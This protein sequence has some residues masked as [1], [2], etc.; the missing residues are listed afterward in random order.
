MKKDYYEVLGVQKESTLQQVKKAYRSKALKYHPDRVEE[1]KKKESEEKFKE[2]SEAYG[3][4]SDPKKRKM[5]DQYGH[6]GIDQ[7]FTSDDIFKGAD[8]GSVF[9]DSGLGDIF[10]QIFGESNFDIFGSSQKG[11]RRAHRGR[12][13][14]YEIEISLEE[15]YSG[16]KKKIK[17]P[18]NEHC[19]ACDG[20]GAKSGNDLKTC[21]TCN[22]RGQV[23]MASGFFRMAQT[24]SNCSGRGQIITDY[25]P[26][27]HGKGA[28][29]ATR[30]IDVNVPAGVNNS[31]R[32]R[33]QNEG[34]IG[35]AGAGDLY[36]YV[37]VLDHD[38][39]E[40]DEQHLYMRLPLSFVKAALGSNVSIPTING[41]VSMKI[42]AGTQSGKVFRLKGRGMPDLRTGITGDLFAR[43]M[44]EVPKKLSKE[45]RKILEEYAKI[46]NEEVSLKGETIKEK[47]KKVFK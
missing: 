8:F 11:S 33:V 22:G 37:H 2:I 1:G 46:S 43:V 41:N 14:Q 19:K 20:S 23:M 21:Q 25:C 30:S 32:L 12:D 24:C 47:I 9:G 7:N 29:R 34:E 15:A 39:F 13:I 28:V 3:V 26:K 42:P 36:L 6:A 5:Y 10:G 17:V 40:R 35:S 44:L 16:V 4:L 45:Q 27:C 38:I 18:R 31:T